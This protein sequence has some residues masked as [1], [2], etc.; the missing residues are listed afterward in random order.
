MGHHFCRIEQLPQ[1][2]LTVTVIDYLLPSR[3]STGMCRANCHKIIKL[4]G[5]LQEFAPEK[6]EIS[7]VHGVR[8]KYLNIGDSAA[9]H[10]FKK[11]AYFVGKLAWPKG[12]DLLFQHMSYVKKRTGKCFDI[13]IYGQGPHTNE[14]VD[15]AKKNK[16][17]AKFH[18]AKDHSLLTDYKVFVNPSLSEVLCTTIVEV[19]VKPPCHVRPA[20]S[21]LSCPC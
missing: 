13:D 10:G 6:E 3:V 2:L 21:A 18:G 11:G 20:M 9:T 15:F 19:C 4:S 17:S 8:V 16:L 1:L 5:A 14:I 7:N 12:L